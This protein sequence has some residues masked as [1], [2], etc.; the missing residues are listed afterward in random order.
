MSADKASFISDDTT[1]PDFFVWSPE[2]G[3][4]PEKTNCAAAGPEEAACEWV[5][6]HWADLDYSTEIFVRVDDTEG[7]RF[8][9]M[10]KAEQHT[11]FRAATPEGP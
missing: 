2:D 9:Y 5:E 7:H 6:R 3:Y 10:V 8:E 4:R 11:T 1:P